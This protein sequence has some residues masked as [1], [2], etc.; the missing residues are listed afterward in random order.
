MRFGLIGLG[1]ATR[2]LHLPA[3]AAIP[4]AVVAGG[5][6]P[7]P[8]ARNAFTE[9]TGAP[10][11]DDPAELIGKARPDVVVVAVPPDLHADVAIA[12]LDAGCHVL[13]EKPLA[14]T[15]ADA[16]RIL[17]AASAA[18]RH[19]AVHHG[20]REQP[21]IRAL[22]DRAGGDA[23][24][25]AFCQ[26][27]QLVGLAP[28]DEPAAWRAGRPDRALLEGGIHL[29]DLVCALYGSVP[30]AVSAR[31]SAGA[32]PRDDADAVQVV[33]LEFAGG[34][35]GLVVMD[36]VSRGGDR[37]LEVRADCE[38][39]SLR[40]SW[41]GRA[42]VQAGKRRAE[43]A[44]VRLQLAA[45]GVAWEERGL[46]RKV[47]ARDPRDPGVA[48]TTALL[49]RVVEALRSGAEPPSSGA[50]ARAVLE[51]VEGAY[52]SGTTGERVEIA[53]AGQP[54]GG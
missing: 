42:M 16:D 29:V 37:Y 41:G 15:V 33:T 1:G 38:Q 11:F 34:R 43:R 10:A 17:A 51:V 23:G 20:F 40:A 21:T 22:R 35:L 44:G 45:G 13:C 7:D 18:G 6:D 9:A 24:R 25:I 4:E 52:R 5:C 2:N 19:V 8:T 3:L 49:R 53:S 12:A 30:E 31:R 36:R 32:E 48:G 28:W 46:R 50:E 26:V 54:I 27:W 47:F 39:A 14:P